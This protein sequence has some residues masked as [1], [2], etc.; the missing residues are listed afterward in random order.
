[1]H[2]YD[3]LMT[4][5]NNP[6]ADAAAY[7]AQLGADGH[8]DPPHAEDPPECERCPGEYAV[9][10][11]GGWLCIECCHALECGEDEA[12]KAAA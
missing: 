7:D 5:T 2:E 8:F 10:W 9:T 6:A 11:D 1:M 3:V 4:H 12:V